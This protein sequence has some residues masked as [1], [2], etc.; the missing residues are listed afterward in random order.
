VISV[1]TACIVLSVQSRKRTMGLPFAQRDYFLSDKMV[2]I[3][4]IFFDQLAHRVGG[5][6]L[7]VTRILVTLAEMSTIHEVF[8]VPLSVVIGAHLCHETSDEENATFIDCVLFGTLFQTLE[9]EFRLSRSR[10]FR[11]RVDF[12]FTDSSTPKAR[13]ENSCPPIH[14]SNERLNESSSD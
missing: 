8:D 7:Y 4:C 12:V 2:H 11:C 13:C 3:Q 5:G 14:A 10:L 6:L 1:F 9:D